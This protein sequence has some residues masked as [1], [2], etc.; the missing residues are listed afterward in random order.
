[1]ARLTCSEN[2]PTTVT[3][4]L[5]QLSQELG[6]YWDDARLQPI[7][8]SAD[9]KYGVIYRYRNP[10]RIGTMCVT[11]NVFQREPDGSM[12]NLRLLR[13]RSRCDVP[14]EPTSISGT[15]ALHGQPR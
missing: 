4:S 13:V 12:V 10:G 14:S 7:D 8:C 1:M 2:Q 5:A 11:W 6:F 15:R 3:E 9:L